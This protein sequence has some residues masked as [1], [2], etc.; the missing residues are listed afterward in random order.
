MREEKRSVWLPLKVPLNMSKGTW[1]A[2][3]AYKGVEHKKQEDNNLLITFCV[4]RVMMV[5]L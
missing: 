1:M 5:L 4:V 3:R 2:T